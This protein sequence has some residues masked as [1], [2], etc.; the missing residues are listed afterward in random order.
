METQQARARLRVTVTWCCDRFCHRSLKKRAFFENF[1][2]IVLF[3]LVGTI[4]SSAVF[5]MGT[6]WLMQLGAI[7]KDSIG[8]LPAI[9]CLMYGTLISCE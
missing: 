9:R 6:F 5:G 7:S 3:A 4:I 1:A 2:A 8:S